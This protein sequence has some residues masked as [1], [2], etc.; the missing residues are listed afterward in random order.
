MATLGDKLVY[1]L[2][3]SSL[4]SLVFFLSKIFFDSIVIASERWT[5]LLFPL[6]FLYS[7]I[8]AAVDLDH[9]I[10][11]SKEMFAVYFSGFG[12]D[13]FYRGQFSVPNGMLQSNVVLQALLENL[14]ER[15]TSTPHDRV[16]ASYAIL[17][18][19][20][21]RPQRP[22]YSKSLGLVYK[23][24][25]ECLLNSYPGFLNLI[26]DVN[27]HPLPDSASWVPNWANK[28]EGTN[29]IGEP[30]V[31]DNRG[32]I[33]AMPALPTVSGSSLIVVGKLIGTVAFLSEPFP[34][35]GAQR[36]NLVDQDWT[37]WDSSHQQAMLRACVQF[38]DW[39]CYMRNSIATIPKY[40]L[41]LP[42]LLAAVLQMRYSQGGRPHSLNH[43][44]IS[45]EEEKITEG[46]AFDTW[47]R[48]IFTVP[49]HILDTARESENIDIKGDFAQHMF[50]RDQED[51]EQSNIISNQ[52]LNL[53]SLL[54]GRRTLFVTDKGYIG[55]APEAMRQGD[56]IYWVQYVS[57][58]M[59]L[60]Q[61]QC[62]RVRT[63][64]KWLDMCLFSSSCC[65]KAVT[66]MGFHLSY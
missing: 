55:S 9:F 18:L 17:S 27:G 47:Y 36:N 39:V 38:A 43:R 37:R 24:H 48:K 15:Q 16:F 32:E 58:P 23:E 45:A 2:E 52:T 21:F 65:Q 50:S 8:E 30:L 6:I 63:S 54:G 51:P 61:R 35:F 28:V 7:L 10:P 25:F 19:L 4:I 59:I 46:E 49:Q 22:D 44:T 29:W 12:I 34:I 11:G 5:V 13:F 60:R 20:N 42:S 40:Q 57:A 41:P 53:C 62:R 64:F 3:L 33:E 26:L 66:L 1:L 14:R 56:Q 31:Y